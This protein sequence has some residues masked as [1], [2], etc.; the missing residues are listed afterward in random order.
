MDYG[1]ALC[2]RWIRLW[3]LEPAVTYRER[4]LEVTADCFW[5]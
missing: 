3:N 2:G 4:M 5:N 1:H